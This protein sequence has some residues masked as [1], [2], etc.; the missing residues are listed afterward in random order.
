MPRVRGYGAFA[1]SIVTVASVYMGAK[2]FQPIVVDQ[3]RKDNNL[4]PDV[5]VPPLSSDA[6]ASLAKDRPHS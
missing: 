3:L 2:F 5:D 6:T 4:R 1:V